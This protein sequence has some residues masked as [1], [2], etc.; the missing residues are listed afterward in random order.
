MK[1]PRVYIK[2]ARYFYVQDL[3]ER[4]A[5]TGRPKQKWHKL[6]RID[7]GDAALHRELAA[8]LGQPPQREGNM[9]ALLAEFRRDHLPALTPDVR[10]EYARMYDVIATAFAEFD[11]AQ[12][13][14]GDV[15]RFLGQ[16]QAK[17]NTRGKY[18]ARLSTFF[19]WCVIN[20]H[21]GVK[22]NPCREIRL[23]APPRRRGGMTGEIFWRLHDALTP[24]GKCFLELMYLTRQRPTEIR[25]LRESAISADSPNSMSR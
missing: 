23:P 12:A 1:I 2:G 13:E 8:L 11:A 10:T 7:E 6:S 15:L 5:R 22:V 17:P 4:H 14:P 25:L 24:M 16:W 21:T 3:E 20:S 19:A 9:P 18:K